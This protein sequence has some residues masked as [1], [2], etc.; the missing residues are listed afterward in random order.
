MS[1]SAAS[2]L[3]SSLDLSVVV[4]TT[5]PLVQALVSDVAINLGTVTVLLPHPMVVSPT[6]PGVASYTEAIANAVKKARSTPARD[7]AKAGLE[8]W[9]ARFQL[10]RHGLQV[11]KKR[12]GFFLAVHQL[13]SRSSFRVPSVG[14]SYS[15]GSKSAE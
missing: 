5:P 15:R 11:T 3:V 2:K 8:G 14:G 9:H 1:L 4:F 10:Q 13:S 7:Q 12:R 6:S